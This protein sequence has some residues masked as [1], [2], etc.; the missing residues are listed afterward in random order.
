MERIDLSDDRSLADAIEAAERGDQVMITRAGK[1]VAEVKTAPLSP[2]T[3]QSRH[4]ALQRLRA[5][6]SPLRVADATLLVREM[7]DADDH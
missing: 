1:V 5:I 4:D 2:R 6:A 7:R 3:D